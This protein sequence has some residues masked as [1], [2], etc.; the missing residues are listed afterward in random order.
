V[1]DDVVA[2]HH[3]A[4]LIMGAG[5]FLRR[6]GPGEV[7][8]AIRSAGLRPYLAVFGT[9]VIGGYDDLD[10]RFD[11]WRVPAIVSLSGNWVGD[12]AAMPVVSGGAVAPNSLKMAEV[13]DAMLYLGPRKSLTEINVPRSE[14]VGTAYGKEVARRYMIQTGQ[15]LEFTQD[16]EASQFYKPM[17]QIVSN[18][19]HPL[20]PHLPKSAIDPL[21]T[22]PPS[23]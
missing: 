21:P 23:R 11:A 20:P 3:R 12:L 8:R 16:S 6:N 14:L 15:T 2:K 17:H 1:K 4:L 13:A 22:R 9:N 7:E 5:H 18:G 10:R 19:Y